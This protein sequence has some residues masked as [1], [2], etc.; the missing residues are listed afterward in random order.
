MSARSR[1]DVPTPLDPSVV[2][3]VVAAVALVF[4]ALPFF[5]GLAPSG[6]VAF[7]VCAA[8]LALAVASVGFQMRRVSGRAAAKKELVLLLGKGQLLFGS[9]GGRLSAEQDRQVR[10]WCAKVEEVLAARLD[11]GHVMRFRM[12]SAP[13]MPPAGGHLSAAQF[14]DRLVNLSTIIGDLG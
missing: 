1:L 10:D 12:A 2:V 14:H 11:A 8:A 4:A 9:L 3:I 7:W 5:P 13:G 6:T